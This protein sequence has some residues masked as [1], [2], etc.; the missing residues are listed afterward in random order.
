MKSYKELTKRY[1][2]ANKKRTMLTIGG[3]ALSVALIF[4][5]GSLLESLN[6]RQLNDTIKSNGNYHAAFMGVTSDEAEKLKNS[7]EVKEAGVSSTLG[8]AVI[9]ENK[10]AN[11]SWNNKSY[12]EVKEYEEKTFNIYNVEIEK[13]NYPKNSNEI[14]LPEEALN[15]MGKSIGDTI[16]LETG[17]KYSPEKDKVLDSSS[18]TD[19]II[20]R[21][22]VK[23]TYT[24]VGIRKKTFAEGPITYRAITHLDDIKSADRTYNV[25]V[26]MKKHKHTY[27]TT[28]QMAE[29]LSL[30]KVTLQN[31]ETGYNIDYNE[32]LLRLIGGSRKENYNDSRGIIIGVIVA[33]VIVS[34]VATIY[35]SFHISVMERKKEFGTLRSVGATPSQIRGIVFREGFF[36]AAV[37][38]P[39]GMVLGYFGLWFVL[40][41][42]TIFLSTAMNH[43]ELSGIGA[44]VTFRLVIIT[45]GLAILTV[46]LSAYLPAKKAGKISPIEAIRSTTDIKVGKVKSGKLASKLFKA[47]GYLAT[48]NLRR[49][50]KKFRITIFSITIS[51]V[52]F[53]V[54]NSFVSLSL[55]VNSFTQSY[56]PDYSCY[57]GSTP[58]SPSEDDIKTIKSF[59][60]V[61]KV[62]T[63]VSSNPIVT[64]DSDK[65]NPKADLSELKNQQ[66]DPEGKKINIYNSK[67]TYPGEDGMKELKKNLSSGEV[68]IAALERENGVILFQTNLSRNDEKSTY[69]DY[70]EY[71]VGDYI[72]FYNTYDDSQ[73]GKPTEKVKVL[74][75]IE[76]PFGPFDYNRQGITMFTTKKVL[77]NIKMDNSGK[78]S[79]MAIETSDNE[80]EGLKTYLKDIADK[81]NGYFNDTKENAKEEKQFQI[82]IQIFLYGFVAVITL[83]SSIN[84]INTITTNVLLR[85]KELSMLQAV[86]M[87][88]KDMHKSIYLES[89]FC[90][91]TAWIYGTIIGSGISYF[92]YKGAV[93]S[94][95]FKWQLPLG[96]IFISLIGAIIIS[97]IAGVIPINKL[98]K[99]NI[100]ENI[101]RESI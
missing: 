3:I 59:K 66:S 81:N 31:G 8:Y 96:A 84:I 77:E 92:L 61:E 27:A 72:E 99:E 15:I 47:E 73:L 71:K 93:R 44:T 67:F 76:K 18:Y 88:T 46:F 97:L 68:D 41:L 7:V 69:V 98:K 49:N 91:F 25:S 39:V 33:L 48:R 12:V 52:L 94:V 6:K 42:L 54:F 101:R 62:Y 20:I 13:G 80:D 26:I 78:I 40:K 10:N 43:M 83:I 19:D 45:V 14:V 58:L 30:E 29:N 4:A 70:T 100:I 23:H 28:K 82:M 64:V 63:I 9:H 55:R 16:E 86:G 87:T 1:L 90:T 95:D 51:I 60:G 53:I 5:I 2:K 74:G 11:D 17:E 37:A 85:K 50:K 79:S 75:I 36:M 65:I 24:I 38:I 22:P 89:L 57:F 32:N 34:T 21:N 35:N 56:M